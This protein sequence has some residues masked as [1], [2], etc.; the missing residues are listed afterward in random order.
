MT[1]ADKGVN[2]QHSGS[3]LVDIHIRISINPEIWI[4]IPDHFR[5]TFQRWRR[6]ALSE[7]SL[8]VI[9]SSF[10]CRVKLFCIT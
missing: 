8:V 10:I 1:D 4:E 3:D 5:L 2:P 7:H 6:L 9:I